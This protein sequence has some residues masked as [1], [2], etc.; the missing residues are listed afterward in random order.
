MISFK[1]TATHRR[2][3]AKLADKLESLSPR[4]GRFNMRWFIDHKGASDKDVAKY[5]EKNGGLEQFE[6]GTMAC[7][8]GHGPAAGVLFR[9]DEMTS[10]GWDYVTRSPISL[11]DWQLYTDRFIPVGRGEI[12]DNQELFMFLFGPQWADIDNHHYGAAARI[13]YV[14]HYGRL[15]DNFDHRDVRLRDKKSYREFDKRVR[16]AHP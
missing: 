9:Q 15:P 16:H 6:C 4:Y 14:L 11:P 2:N 13:R 12:M 5:A 8:V 10:E 3:L 1:L 7:A